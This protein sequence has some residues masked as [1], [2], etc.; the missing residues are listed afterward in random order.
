VTLATPVTENSVPVVAPSPSRLDRRGRELRRYAIA[1]GAVLAIACAVAAVILVLR[2]RSASEYLQIA[3]N[4]QITTSSGL[5]FYP[6]LSPD[7][8]EIA[9]S[10]DRGKGFEIFVRQLTP[11]G[12]EV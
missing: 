10:T 7:G 12:K 11:G 3:S 5:S 6:T 1:G 9:Y 2:W 4:T 8:T